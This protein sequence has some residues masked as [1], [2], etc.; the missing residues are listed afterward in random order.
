MNVKEYRWLYRALRTPND[1]E[2]LSKELGYDPELLFVIYTQRTI[3]RA[4]Y[5][6]YKIK[7]QD[8]RLHREWVQGKS[9]VS[10]AKYL[11]FP[12]VL[13]GLIILQLDG[14]TRK[15]YRQYLN[16][17]N[18]VKNKR[19]Q[20]DLK[21]VLKHDLIYSP[22]G[23]ELQL[24]RGKKG[25]ETIQ[26]W[27]IKHNFKFQTENDLKL[28]FP[29]TPDFL[30][31]TPINVRGTEVHWI[32]SKASFGDPR[33]IMKNLKNQL[34]PYRDLFGNGMVIYLFGFVDAV[35]I[36]DGILIESKNFFEDWQE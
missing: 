3:R 14:I 18:L 30:L 27:L 29:K 1:V 10:L 34:I 26:N 32:E 13:L 15:Q 24:V 31:D 9:I 21:Q 8:T 36:N 5:M 7:A 4:S 17:L 6:F 28:K 20:T 35:P 16:D 23:Y 19:I 33:E 11:N 2:K 12:P 22:Q 25:E